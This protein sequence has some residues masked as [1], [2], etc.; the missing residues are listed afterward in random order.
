MSLLYQDLDV[1][2]RARS[3]SVLLAQSSILAED[4]NTGQRRLAAVH[5]NT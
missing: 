5:Q 3:E 1:F 2:R 4:G